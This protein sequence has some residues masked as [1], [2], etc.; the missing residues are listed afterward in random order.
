[1]I[2][3]AF[4]QLCV[5]IGSKEVNDGVVSLRDMTNGQQATI[6]RAELSRTLSQR[7]DHFQQAGIVQAVPKQGVAHSN[8][9]KQS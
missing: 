2:A 3:D 8:E 1:M 6:P 9:K 7:L 4:F 5:V